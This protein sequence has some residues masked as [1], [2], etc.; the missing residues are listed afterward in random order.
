MKTGKSR[1]ES[2]LLKPLKMKQKNSESR[3]LSM[4]LGTSAASLLGKALTDLNAWTR[5]NKITE[6]NS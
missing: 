6:M 1:Q 4:L 3:F 5:N 2:R